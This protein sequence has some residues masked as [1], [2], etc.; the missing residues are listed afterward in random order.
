MSSKFDY[1]R[2]AAPYKELNLDK[3]EGLLV[4]LEVDG[5]TRATE[6]DRFV[7][8]GGMIKTNGF[9]LV[10]EKDVTKLGSHEDREVEVTR[11]QE[12]IIGGSYPV[13]E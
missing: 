11:W 4:N 2:L 13:K 7:A 6:L 1:V 3:E 5:F 8:R 9:R 10:I 12:H